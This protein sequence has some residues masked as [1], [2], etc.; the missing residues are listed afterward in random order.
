MHLQ[1]MCEQTSVGLTWPVKKFNCCI[2]AALQHGALF[3][4]LFEDFPHKRKELRV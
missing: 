2:L 3:W 1:S 4:G